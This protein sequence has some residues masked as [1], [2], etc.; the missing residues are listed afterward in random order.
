MPEGPGGGAVIT[1]QRE[2]KS[3]SSPGA[4]ALVALRAAHPVS[5]MSQHGASDMGQVTVAAACICVCVERNVL[6]F[7]LLFVFVCVWV[8]VFCFFSKRP[9]AFRQRPEKFIKLFNLCWNK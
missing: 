8:F 2:G 4:P 3:M 6:G 1:S 9:S 5:C 7:L